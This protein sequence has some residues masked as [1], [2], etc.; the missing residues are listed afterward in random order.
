MLIFLLGGGSLLLPPFLSP[1]SRALLLLGPSRAPP[2]PATP[3]LISAHCLFLLC[4]QCL[5][6]L[7]GGRAGAIRRG[8][9]FSQQVWQTVGVAEGP[10]EEW[11]PD[12]VASSIRAWAPPD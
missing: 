5:I 10:P 4:V 8:V 2:I 12:W 6:A 3:K 7:P 11:G 9:S 1:P